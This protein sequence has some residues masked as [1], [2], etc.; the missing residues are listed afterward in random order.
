MSRIKFVI[1]QNIN[2]V[3]WSLTPISSA[4]CTINA[5]KS[6]DSAGWFSSDINHMEIRRC[7]TTFNSSGKE[8]QSVFANNDRE[9]GTRKYRW[10]ASTTIPF[11]SLSLSFSHSLHFFIYSAHSYHTFSYASTYWPFLRRRRVWRRDC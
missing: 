2:P 5:N 6:S 3:F 11:H 7:Q 8:K 1:Q 4:V 9:K 10:P